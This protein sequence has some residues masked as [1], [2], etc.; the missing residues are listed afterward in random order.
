[1]HSFKNIHVQQTG[2][3]VKPR[4]LGREVPGSRPII[5]SK[6]SCGLELEQVTFRNCLS[7]KLKRIHLYPRPISRDPSLCL[8]CTS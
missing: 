7:N 2:A 4:T 6:L 5:L 1:M 3:V 8:L